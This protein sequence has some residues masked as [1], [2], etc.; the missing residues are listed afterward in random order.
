M[1]SLPIFELTP[2]EGLFKVTLDHRPDSRGWFEEVW[3][4]DKW[5][6]GPLAWFRPIQ[7]NCSSN[8]TAGSTRG[9]HAEPW[10]KL[11]TTASGKAFCAWVDLRSGKNFG[12]THWSNLS[13]GEAYFVPAGV[14]NGYQ[15]LEPNTVYTYLVDDHWIPD[16]AYTAVDL[17]DKVLGI[18]W[19]IQLQ[20]AELS[21]KDLHNPGF[22]AN[23]ALPKPRVLVFGASGQVGSELAHLIPNS[24]PMSR[25]EGL[26]GLAEN[27]GLSSTVINAAAFTNVDEAESQDSWPQALEGNQFLVSQ[28]ASITAKERALFVH[29]SSDYVFDGRRVEP[30]SEDDLP[31]PISRYGFSKLLG[32]LAAQSNPR[33]FLI[34]TSWVFGQ[35]RN[36]LSTIY[37]RAASGLPSS[38]IDD[39]YGRPTWSRDIAAFTKHLIDI[40][41]PFGTYNFSGSG[42]RVSWYDLACLVY[43]HLGKDPNLVARVSSTEYAAKNPGTA[44]RPSNG[45]LNLKKAEQTMF[46]IPGWRESVKSYLSTL[47]QSATP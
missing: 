39:Q 47:D 6:A 21:E 29:Y 37:E 24:E 2:I 41:A 16:K 20:D 27:L 13:P 1:S 30:W 5:G 12:A 28:L 8:L 45:V 17:F 19:P 10:N 32:D 46:E 42:E 11:V 38:V 25:G 14:A 31:N 15:S 9:L 26:E 44:Q 7:Q 4:L 22:S 36:F 40:K 33:H 3:H 18:P 34:R 35:G 23:L 43:Q